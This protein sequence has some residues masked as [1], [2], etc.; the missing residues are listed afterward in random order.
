MATQFQLEDKCRYCIC[1]YMLDLRTC[2]MHSYVQIVYIHKLCKELH[3]Q[4]HA[5]L[6]N[7]GSF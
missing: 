4:K 5:Q 1:D 3:K 2:S 7:Y 6:H